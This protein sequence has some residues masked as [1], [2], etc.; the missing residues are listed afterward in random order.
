M[1]G[2]ESDLAETGTGTGTT[3]KDSLLGTTEEGA[4]K[5]YELLGQRRWQGGVGA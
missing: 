3:T 2:G 1:R 4:R 5:T